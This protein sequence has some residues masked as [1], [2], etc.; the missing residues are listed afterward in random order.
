MRNGK[1]VLV[2]GSS[3][4]IGRGIV[5]AFAKA[6]YDVAVHYST[7]KADAEQVCRLAQA[8]GV[9]VCLVQGDT[10]DSTVP[11]RMVREAVE[12]LGR[13]DVFVA[14]AGFFAKES[15]TQ[16][17]TELMDNLYRINFRGMV[18]GAQAAAQY[19]LQE[20]IAGCILVNTSVRAYSAH[21][22]DCMYG[23]LKAAMNRIIR[24]FAM[25]LG[26]SGIRVCGF[27]PG[28]IN[29]SCPEPEA[30]KADAFY[31]NT[32]RFVPLRRNGYANDIADPVVFLAS[33]AARYITGTI[34]QIDGGLSAVGAPEDLTG[35]HQAFDLAGL[36]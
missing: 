18:L 25:E 13:L 19:F 24:S 20:K 23:A 11:E 32:H 36:L 21:T 22:D 16:M 12:K 28:I 27:A 14:N 5:L 1:A 35:L 10:A 29:V 34:L 2:S 7:S 31:S 26:P 15:L 9:R 33:D 3:K 30:E 8:R 4:G 17:S 6:G